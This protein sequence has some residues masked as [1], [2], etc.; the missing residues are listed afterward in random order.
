MRPVGSGAG[1]RKAP[2][3]RPPLGTPAMA[4]K[5]PGTGIVIEWR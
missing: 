1:D 3:P 5:A 2:V 4:P